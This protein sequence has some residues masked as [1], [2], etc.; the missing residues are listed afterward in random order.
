MVWHPAFPFKLLRSAFFANKTY[1]T[2]IVLNLAQAAAS[3]ISYR[4]VVCFQLDLPGMPQI[5]S[6]F[7][8]LPPN[9]MKNELDIKGELRT[10][11]SITIMN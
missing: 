7:M 11:I 5:P 4:A 3:F 8:F 2:I 9:D 10:G 6:A 1:L